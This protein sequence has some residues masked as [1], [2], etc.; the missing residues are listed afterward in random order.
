MNK[1]HL[2]FGFAA[3]L[4]VGGVLLTSC[5]DEKGNSFDDGR[6]TFKGNYVI[7]ASAGSSDNSTSYLLTAESLDG[8]E[9]S[10]YGSGK[11]FE[12]EITYWVFYDENYFFGLT[13]NKGSNGTGG[14]YFLDADNV[15]QKKYGYSFQRITSYGKWGENVI[16]VS[17]GDTKIKDAQGNV[18][19]G[20]LFN[21]LNANDGTTSTNTKDILAE[22]YLGN[23]EKVTMAGFVE[24]NGKLYTSIIPMGMSHYGVNTWPERVLN[25]DYVAKKQGG[26]GSGTYTP[27]QIPSTQIPDS[28]FIA[29]YSGD[30]F[31]GTPV[32]ARTNKIGFACGRL[33]S[34][35][36]QT[37]WSDDDGNIYAFSGGYGRTTTDDAS[38]GL[39]RAKGTLPS[40]VVRIPKGATDFDGYYC[41][42]ETME[43]ATGHPLFRCWH[44]GGDY[45][46]LNNYGCSIEQVTELGTSAPA[47]E[48]V[49]FKASEKKLIKIQGLPD[50]S[51]ISSFGDSPYLEGNHFYITVL[52]TEDGAKPTFYKI[53]PQTGEAVKGLVVEADDVSTVGKVAL[54]K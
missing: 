9:I 42:L 5:D 54:I 30:N 10:V 23:G 51:I 47:N 25:Q 18:A 1:K 12:D 45:F 28:A 39:K 38:T 27:G 3:V 14:C 20:F 32:I 46:L 29:I 49:I 48:M 15:P 6:N 35:Y 33:R 2:L 53:N 13:Y 44:V 36:Y 34:Q 8:G 24:A 40:G 50:T 26:S 52:T 37:I 7:P 41:N 16:T 22:N 4:C 21:Y 11:E 43:G 19:Q 17:T 31:D